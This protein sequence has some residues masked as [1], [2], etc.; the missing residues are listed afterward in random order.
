MLSPLM[1]AVPLL[2]LSLL[3]SLLPLMLPLPLLMLPLVD[4]AAG[5]SRE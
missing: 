2:M 1:L 3:S 5:C 4:A